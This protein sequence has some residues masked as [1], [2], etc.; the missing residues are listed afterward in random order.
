LLLVRDRTLRVV[1][2]FREWLGGRG[3]GDL[4]D[5]AEAVLTARRDYGGRAD[6]TCWRSGDIHDLMT[7]VV[8]ARMTDISRIAQDGVAGLGAFL[9]FLE[10][11]G[12]LHPGSLHVKALK[13]ELARVAAGF[14]ATMGDRRKWRMA[15]TLYEAM[16]AE[17]VDITRE[18]AVQA[19]FAQFNLAADER[20]RAVLAYLLAEQ[21]ELLDAH[22]VARD[23]QVAALR[24]AE[25]A[26][27]GLATIPPQFHPAEPETYR[28]VRLTPQA[29]L[30][31][32]ARESL[33]LRQA[34]AFVAWVGAGRPV[35]KKGQ[36]TP[37]PAAEAVAFVAEHCG[38]AFCDVL[39][40]TEI[41]PLA[42]AMGWVGLRRNGLIR[43]DRAGD[44]EAVVDGSVDDAA[45]LRVWREA[46]DCLVRPETPD[47]TTGSDTA[48]LAQSMDE[49]EPV[50]A[51]ALTAL[52]Q[53]DGPLPQEELLAEAVADSDLEGVTEHAWAGLL[54]ETLMRTRLHGA[55]RHGAVDAL[56]GEAHSDESDAVERA[57]ALGLQPWYA[58]DTADLA[59][60]L[61]PLGTWGVRE[62]LLAEGNI[63]PV[64]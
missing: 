42:L 15:K 11:T 10:D 36:L 8:P 45:A 16:R 44:L 2:S 33:V 21:P 27:L 5:P 1:V 4:A 34:A 28:P 13:K 14:E 61:T 57:A 59:F 60:S 35:D 6:P 55:W 37:K 50:T 26:R 41:A 23:G 24:R 40:T 19:W 43:G 62:A 49:A 17:G 31:A 7:S 3:L 63:T 30:A 64:S 12:R 53:A 48:K 52:Y 9:D 39:L 38:R 46:L 56:C 18:D 47:Y 54:V 51:W 58:L 32:V 29:Q 25:F 20:R 22:F